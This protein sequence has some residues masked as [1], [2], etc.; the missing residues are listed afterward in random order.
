MRSIPH[1]SVGLALA[2]ALALGSSCST[3]DEVGHTDDVMCREATADCDTTPP[4]VPMSHVFITST[5]ARV[6]LA[7]AEDQTDVYFFG[8]ALGNGAATPIEAADRVLTTDV[9]LDTSAFAYEEKAAGI[10]ARNSD[11]NIVA[12]VSPAQ[13]R[14]G[15]W[16]AGES[17]SCR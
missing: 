13:L 7:C 6:T 8:L 2:V 1:R 14:D 16:G 10:V 5:G 3:T 4:D 17:V 9:S 15:T 12:W 11:G